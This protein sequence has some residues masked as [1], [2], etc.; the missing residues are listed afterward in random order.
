MRQGTPVL[1]PLG[2]GRVIYVRNAP[3]DYREPEAVS[4]LLDS[5]KL[6]AAFGRYHGTVFPAREVRPATPE[7]P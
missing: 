4:V 2:P 6:D 5:R 7:V 1:T 3:P